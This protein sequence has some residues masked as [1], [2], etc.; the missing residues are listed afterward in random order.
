MSVIGAWHLPPHNYPDFREDSKDGKTHRK[1][2]L[3]CGHAIKEYHT[4]DSSGNKCEKCSY[5]GPM[6]TPLVSGEKEENE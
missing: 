4:P 3:A 6:I 2:C 5:T 1:L